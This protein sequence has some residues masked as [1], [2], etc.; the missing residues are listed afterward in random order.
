MQNLTSLN[1]WGNAEEQRCR[2]VVQVAYYIVEL[3][4]I[5]YIVVVVERKEIDTD[6][7]LFKEH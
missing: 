1:V 3:N 6:V 5:T 2:I 4:G 7:V